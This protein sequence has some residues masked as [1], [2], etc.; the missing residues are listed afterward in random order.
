MYL[1]GNPKTLE[2]IAG[3]KILK[4]HVESSAKQNPKALTATRLSKYLATNFYHDRQRRDTLEQ[5][6]T[7]MGVGILGIIYSKYIP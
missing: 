2:P 1:F 3:Y 6:S 5:L 7:F 4:K